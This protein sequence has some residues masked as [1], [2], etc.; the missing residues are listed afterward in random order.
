MPI[1]RPVITQPEFFENHARHEQIFDP[2]L[3]LVGQMHRPLTRD[4]FDKPARLFVQPC[5]HRVSGNG[6]KIGSDGADIF[7]DRP[8]IVVEHDD[9]TLR[10]RFSVVQCFVT[11]PAGKSGISRH[12]HDV[13][14]IVATQIPANCH[15]QPR[16]QGRAGMSRAVAIVFAFG[17]Q[18]EPVQSLVLPHRPNAIETTGKHFVDV[19][20]MA[21]IE[22]EA[23]LRS[24]ENA[25][26]R[27]GQFDHA[28]V[29]SEMAARL[30]ENFD[31][32]LAHFLSELRQILLL[33][34]L[35]I[36]WSANAIEQTGPVF[37]RV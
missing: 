14:I 34:R 17:A 13:L 32:L 22:N 20:L 12:Y 31:Q 6:V 19:A 16:R 3:E 33:N 21:D 8:F 2:L 24:V 37:R 4:R 28:K 5:V 35:H 15:P 30:R 29:G 7:C 36:R 23:I 18:Q 1:D 27:D 9:E 11:D 10:L 25:M 26:E